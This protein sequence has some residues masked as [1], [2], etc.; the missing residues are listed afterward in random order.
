MG[1]FVEAFGG[2]GPGPIS[3]ESIAGAQT[4]LT[5][6]QIEIVRQIQS[7]QRSQAEALRSLEALPGVVQDNA[8]S[9]SAVPRGAPPPQPK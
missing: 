5:P 4:I 1:G 8:N 3:D 2:G 9:G 7:E 6:A